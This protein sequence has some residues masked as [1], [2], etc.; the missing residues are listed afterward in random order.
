MK[1]KIFL[2]VFLLFLVS[3]AYSASFEIGHN[4]TNVI[5]FEGENATFDLTIK[6]NQAYDTFYKIDSVDYNWNLINKLSLVNIKVPANQEKTIELKLKPTKGLEKKTYGV[7][8]ITTSQSTGERIEKII[9]VSLIN[10]DDVFDVEFSGPDEIDPRKENNKVELKIKNNFD[11]NYNDLT[12]VMVSDIFSE[13]STIDLNAKETKIEEY[14]LNI[15]DEAKE[16]IHEVEVSFYYDNELIGKNNIDLKISQYSGVREIVTKED[17]LLINREITKKI[18]SGN[19]IAFQK[20]TKKISFFEKLFTETNPEP[21]IIEKED[22]NYILIWN[23]RLEP[24]EETEITTTT[25]YRTP[26]IILL[27]AI[28]VSGFLYHRFKKEIRITKKVFTIK[29][30]KGTSK[31]KVILT[32]KN[33]SKKELKNVRVMERVNNIVEKPHG[34]GSLEPFK[35]NKTG[36]SVEIIWKLKDMSPKEEV[37]ISYNVETKVHK[38]GKLLL[39]PAL[40]RYITD[41]RVKISKSNRMVISK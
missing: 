19:A 4:P 20:F 15:D 36:N 6:N 31:M 24:E 7:N 1:N 18:N 8:I 29:S 11:N 32:L 35:I 13:T 25:D 41:K 5:V 21:D 17:S 27:I 37:V 26:L 38:I 33:K 28:L 23:L 16:G 2:M 12:V 9:E 39:P 40:A 22:G 3:L 30:E 34:F 14:I 10:E